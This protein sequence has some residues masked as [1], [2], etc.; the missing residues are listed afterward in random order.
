MFLLLFLHP[1]IHKPL[2]YFYSYG[3]FLVDGPLETLGVT[4]SY[5]EHSSAV[6]VKDGEW[7]GGESGLWHPGHTV[8]LTSSID[9]V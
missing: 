2:P 5:F 6:G 7:H 4:V 1:H 9:G 3:S 8:W